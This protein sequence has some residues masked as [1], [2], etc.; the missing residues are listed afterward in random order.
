MNNDE[1]IIK[2]LKEINDNMNKI[3]NQLV[4]IEE[5]ICKVAPK[6]F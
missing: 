2:Q 3:L 4:D 6:D 5:T 1:R